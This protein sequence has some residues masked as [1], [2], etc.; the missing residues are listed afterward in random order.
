MEKNVMSKNLE[1]A[2]KYLSVLQQHDLA[3]IYGGSP[4]YSGIFL[5]SASDKYWKSNIK[6][7]IVGKEPRG[8]LDNSCAGKLSQKF[9]LDDVVASLKQHEESLRVDRPKSKFIQFYRKSCIALN[10]EKK[11]GESIIWSNLICISRNKKSPVGSKSFDKVKA[12]SEQ[13][14]RAQIEVLK[15]TVI[16]FVTG[17]SYDKYIRAFFPER[18]ASIRIVPG[19]LWSF[20]IDDAQC[21]R[22]SHPQW[23]D[24]A[25]H[26]DQALS[27]AM[28]D[29]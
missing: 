15:P 8:W 21:F 23:G 11:L 10:S 12:L 22:T 17:T 25:K 2:E 20:K 7:M 13:L 5:P 16:L 1:L 6:T 18:A 24:G 26:R 14:L 28:G 19:K 9:E 29:T 3:A 27:L 4:E